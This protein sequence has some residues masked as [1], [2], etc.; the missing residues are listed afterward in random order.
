MNRLYLA[1]D[2][3]NAGQLVGSAVLMDDAVGLK[4][5]SDKI[6]AGLE[7]A[8]AWVA[9][10]G[11]QIISAGGDEFSAM[12]EDASCENMIEDAR[13]QW[14][15]AAGFT[16]TIGVGN[17]LSQAGKALIAGKLHGKNVTLRYDQDVED[18]LKQVHEEHPQDGGE[19]EKMN[20]HYLDHVYGGQ[21]D[22]IQGEE[23]EQ[24]VDPSEWSE[25]EPQDEEMQSEMQEEMPEDDLSPE[26]EE[27]LDVPAGEDEEGF[28]EELE[29]SQDEG[30][31]DVHAMIQAPESQDD[32]SDDAGIPD[33]EELPEFDAED[34]LGLDDLD[35]GSDITDEEPL[36]IPVNPA[37]EDQIDPES[38]DEATKDEM[39]LQGEA[40]Q[41]APAEGDDMQDLAAMLDGAGSVD[42]IYQRIAQ[43]L[44]QFKQNKDIIEQIKESNPELYATIIGLFQN[45]IELAKETS[46]EPVDE[47]A[48]GGQGEAPVM[49]EAPQEAD[50]PKQNG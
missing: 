41:E 2:F 38:D 42:E 14:G 11:G 45:L 33:D 40:P 9:Q 20:E 44:E 24:N 48:A 6:N 13:N 37:A 29:P 18:F 43:N 26:G 17:S 4:N 1:G 39:D 32:M 16:L 8:K 34:D 23:H 27:G 50:L 36:D 5:I 19:A 28:Q 31:E 47:Q 49:D 12:F 3:D 46:G 30:A 35:T 7:A 22:D 10:N 25:E 21:D 15:Q